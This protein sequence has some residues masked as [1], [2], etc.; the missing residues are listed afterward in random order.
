MSAVLGRRDDRPAPLRLVGQ[1]WVLARRSLSH[2][3]A[4]PA[5]IAGVAIQPV[6]MLVL[7]VYVLGGAISGSVDAYLQFALPGQLVL[8]SA[9]TAVHAGHG[10]SAELRRGTGERLRALPVSPV[11]VIGG[12]VV[13]ATFRM[14]VA[15]LVVLVVGALLGFELA[16]G[17]TGAAGGLLLAAAFG[18]ALCWPMAYIASRAATPEL[19]TAWGFLI[20]F[21][22]LFLSSIFAPTDSMPAGLGA[23]VELSPVTN[24]VD[25]VRALMAG[26][27]AQADL[28]PAVAWTVAVTLFFG[29]LAASAYRRRI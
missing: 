20:V 2:I 22:L 26:G 7:F 13:A 5:Q 27:A 21:P 10:L 16:N 17:V 23:L 19:A 18:F 9:L 14:I 6:V 1:T 3:R 29:V 28:V 12:R 4:D 11:A 15:G 25:S 8:A 24:V